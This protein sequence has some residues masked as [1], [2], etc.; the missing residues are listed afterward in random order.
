MTNVEMLPP[1]FFGPI[2]SRLVIFEAFYAA[3]INAGRAIRFIYLY[4]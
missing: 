3:S 1:A 4:D 2:S